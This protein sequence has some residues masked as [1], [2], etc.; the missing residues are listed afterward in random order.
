MMAPVFERVAS[1]MEPFVQFAK[2]NTETESSLAALANVRSIPTLV[3]YQGG[4]EIA[5]IAGA[6]DE[7]NLKNWIISNLKK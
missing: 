7:A 5:R 6:M 4:N 3:L 2:V 1:E